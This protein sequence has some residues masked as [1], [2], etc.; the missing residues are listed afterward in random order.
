MD[1]EI[2]VGQI[3]EVIKKCGG[4][5]LESYKLFD[6]YEGEQIAKHRKHVDDEIASHHKAEP[7]GEEKAET[8]EVIEEVEE[9]EETIFER[10][11]EKE[12][13]AEIDR[14]YYE[15]ASQLLDEAAST[16]DTVAPEPEKKPVPKAKPAAKPAQ[17]TKTA[18]ASLEELMKLME[19]EQEKLK[20][21]AFALCRA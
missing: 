15:R 2:F 11:A 3:E 4:K 8:E 20:K 5:L 13:R 18:S 19:Q 16:E 12:E 9:V 10:P 14:S 1:K 17:Q 6:V 7:E 21:Q